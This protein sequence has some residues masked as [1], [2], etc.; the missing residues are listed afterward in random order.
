MPAPIPLSPE[1]RTLDDLALRATNPLLRARDVLCVLLLQILHLMLAESDAA[2]AL[3]PCLTLARFLGGETFDLPPAIEAPLRLAITALMRRLDP[4]AV[5]A[6]PRPAT[7]R[8][9]SRRPAN[10]PSRR[11]AR[12]RAHAQ[13]TPILIRGLRPRCHPPPCVKNWSFPSR[14]RTPISFRYRNKAPA[15]IVP[16]PAPHPP[17]LAPRPFTL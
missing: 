5:P 9:Q 13:V 4:G 6:P 7:A 12:A 1:R 10:A 16:R 2:L 8:P 11:A 3:Y 14:H 17:P 15:T